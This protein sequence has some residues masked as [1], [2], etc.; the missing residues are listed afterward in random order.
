MLGEETCK[1][2]DNILLNNNVEL[3]LQAGADEIIITGEKSMLDEIFYTEELLGKFHFLP[4]HDDEPTFTALFEKYF[5]SDDKYF[6]LLG[7]T[8]GL[9]PAYYA[10][11]RNQ[12]GIDEDVC[13][14]H[15]A[16]EERVC[17]AGILHIEASTLRF[18]DETTTKDQFIFSPDAP[19][20]YFLFS[21]G[22]CLVDTLADFR[23]LYRRLSH[24]ENI[25]LCSKY[26]YDQFTEI[27]IEFKELLK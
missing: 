4:R 22:F 7:N 6:I 12:L 23:E 1:V 25:H 21:N 10:G 24:R 20:R 11:L 16:S 8:F 9:S 18:L 26:F 14:V 3:L 2:I 15:T 19:D 17:G 27:F 13:V 5:H